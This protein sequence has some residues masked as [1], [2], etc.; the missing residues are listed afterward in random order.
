MAVAPATSPAQGPDPD[1]GAGLA[2]SAARSRAAGSG[3]SAPATPAPDAGAH[4]RGS[5]VERTARPGADR[6]PGRDRLGAGRDAPRAH[7]GH[8][9][10]GATTG[11]EARSASRGPDPSVEA[12][13]SRSPRPRPRRPIRSDPT[14]ARAA[15]R[16]PVPSPRKPRPR[17]GGGGSADTRLI[18]QLGM[19]FSL[20][21]VAFLCVWF[22]ATRHLRADGA[23]S[24]V[25]LVGRRMR[26]WWER[27][28]A[29]SGRPSRA[30]APAQDEGPASAADDAQWSCEIA[31]QPG[32]LRFQA[33]MAPNEAAEPHCRRRQGPALAAGRPEAVRAR[34]GLRHGRAVRVDR[35]CGVG[36]GPLGRRVVGAAFRVAEGRRAA[37]QLRARRRRPRGLR[38]GRVAAAPAA[39]PAGRQPPSRAADRGGAPRA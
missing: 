14:P 22:R 29:G 27:A 20:L 36:T 31:Y 19:L 8:D 34:A 38:S 6:G 15:S 21:Y 2:G 37:H 32:K 23:E 30:R 7:A 9:A 33:V 16:R 39:R 13:A 3:R 4:A 35:G 11:A 26:E 17:A 12:H 5:G 18:L 28:F 24:V 1:P 25:A 10:A